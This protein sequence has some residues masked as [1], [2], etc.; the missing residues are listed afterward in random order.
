MPALTKFSILTPAT[1][2]QVNVTYGTHTSTNVVVTVTASK[3]FLVVA[4]Y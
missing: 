1:V 2:G 3:K 4:E